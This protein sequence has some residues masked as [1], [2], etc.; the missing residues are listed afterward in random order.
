MEVLR[1]TI[2]TPCTRT[3]P[4]A[5]LRA[6]RS[7]TTTASVLHGRM[8]STTAAQPAQNGAAASRLSIAQYTAKDASLVQKWHSRARRHRRRHHRAPRHPRHPRQ[9]RASPSQCYL[10]TIQTLLRPGR[11][12]QT[13]WSTLDPSLA[14]ACAQQCWCTRRRQRISMALSPRDPGSGAPS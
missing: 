6:K 10:P 9:S 2:R 1:T 8:S 3:R 12:I 7:A 14:A 11:S 5:R 4:Q 13:R